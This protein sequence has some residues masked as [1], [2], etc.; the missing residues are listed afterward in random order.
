MKILCALGR[1]DYGDPARGAGHEF[2]H[3]VPSL[4]ALGHEVVVFDSLDRTRYRDFRELNRDLVQVIE[5]AA[6][7][8][9]FSVLMH[10]EIWSET[11]AFAR[12]KGCVA[13]NWTTDDSWRY[14]SFSRLVAPQFDAITTTYPAAAERYRQ[15]SHDNVFLTQW[16]VRP[17]MLAPPR[18]ARECEYGITFVGAAYGD[19]RQRIEALRRRGIDVRC[20][21]HGWEAGPVPADEIPTIVRNSIASLN[22]ASSSRHS[23]RTGSANQLKARIFEVTGAGGCLVTEE[24]PALRSSY[25]VGAEVFAF[26]DE[27]D[28]VETLRRIMDDFDLRDAVAAAGFERT[29][30]DHTYVQRFPAVLDFA[31]DRA[32]RRSKPTGVGFEEACDRHR[33]TLALRALRAILVGI[34]MLF[35]GRRR[36]ERAGRRIAFEVSWRLAGAVTYSAAGWPGRMFYEAS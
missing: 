30:T 33:L 19:R 21:G 34:C 15:D 35:F 24:A 36:A 25:E 1:N 7:D 5:N 8:V 22:F 20:F 12:S 27:D 9:L 4:E 11:F 18:P 26:N 6:P 16:A 28:L 29:R 17:D 2:A 3:F 13:V 23:R 32:T 10:Y 14:R 31:I